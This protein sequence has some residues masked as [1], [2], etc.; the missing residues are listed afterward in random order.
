M[1]LFDTNVDK[2][3]F[4]G[5]ILFIISSAVLLVFN[6][7]K[8]FI[9][10]LL[11][12]KLLRSK[13]VSVN[14][15]LQKDIRRWNR[16][17]W[18]FFSLFTISLL[19]TVLYGAL[20]FGQGVAL[21]PSGFKIIWGRWLVLTFI[22]IVFVYMTAAVVSVKIMPA[23]EQFFATFYSALTILAL[24]AAT[25]SQSSSTRLLWVFFSLFFGI[26]VGLLLIFTINMIHSS[27]E[28]HREE[29]AYNKKN[30][31]GNSRRN[32]GS[33]NPQQYYNKN[34]L[35]PQ[36]SQGNSTIQQQPPTYNYT[37]MI[38]FA[39]I[40]LAYL[41][42]FMVWILSDSNELIQVISFPAEVIT[43]LVLDVIFIYPITLFL[44]IRVNVSI[45]SDRFE[46]G[47]K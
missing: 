21:R 15:R 35:K 3:F 44:L 29:E 39:V 23:P 33:Y 28:T 37:K 6:A 40:V 22:S 7:V 24:L 13:D 11:H 25:L 2:A 30:I 26:L 41:A 10:E 31:K 12:L 32:N 19:F 9:G 14:T 45:E 43:Y 47:K 34:N 20:W 27:K 38:F 1:G 8:L 4:S 42:Y 16:F 17:K 5:F 36:G 46:Y 18:V